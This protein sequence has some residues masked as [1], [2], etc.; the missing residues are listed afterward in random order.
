MNDAR[1]NETAFCD[2][3]VVGATKGSLGY[4]G[5]PKNPVSGDST[6]CVVAPRLP[7][8]VS[9]CW[10]GY[11]DD[12][13]TSDAVTNA[14]SQLRQALHDRV[15]GDVPIDDDDIINGASDV[16]IY[17]LA[18]EAKLGA[19]YIHGRYETAC[20]EEPATEIT[21]C[22]IVR[23]RSKGVEICWDIFTPRSTCNYEH[24]KKTSNRIRQALLEDRC[25]TL[26]I[27][28]GAF[29]YGRRPCDN[30]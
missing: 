28:V 4:T 14:A 18:I 16:D 7:K 30:R 3:Y 15:C 5:Y 2:Y 13:C 17:R 25:G 9:N 19:C 20:I 26:D 22:L 23:D 1:G 6:G 10:N 27:N 21:G 8:R 29:I 24:L 11:T 12:M